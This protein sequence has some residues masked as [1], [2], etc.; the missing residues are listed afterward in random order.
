M[1]D[2]VE[3]WRDYLTSGRSFAVSADRS[4]TEAKLRAN[5]T[6]IIFAA[7]LAA[8]VL[9]GF[10]LLLVTDAGRLVTYL[11]VGLFVISLLVV[12]LRLV[13]VRKRL[14]ACASAADPLVI[15]TAES[16]TFSG[17]PPIL[18]RDVL[19]VAA[20]DLVDD[21]AAAVGVNRWLKRAA[22]RTGGAMI[23][24]TMGLERAKAYKAGATGGL[25]HDLV[26]VTDGNGGISVFLDNAMSIDQ[27]RQVVTAIKV[28][29]WLNGVGFLAANQAKDGAEIAA[30]WLKG[31]RTPRA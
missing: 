7:A 10:I 23:G 29:A 9:A 6:G 8:L 13:G 21:Y 20:S 17:V 19:G 4:I 25:A 5:R 26:A 28:A 16:L 15:V 14:R 22:V 18:W 2:A 12:L 31:E 1:A 30:K 24:L 3:Q 11:L 27:A